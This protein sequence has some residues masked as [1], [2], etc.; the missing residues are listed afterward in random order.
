MRIDETVVDGV[1]ILLVLWSADG[2]G[3]DHVG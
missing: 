1:S 2:L 3:T